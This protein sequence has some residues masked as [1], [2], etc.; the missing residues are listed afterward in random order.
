MKVKISTVVAL[1]AASCV[2]FAA[3]SLQPQQ[4]KE[5]TKEQ[6]IEMMKQQAATAP[7]HKVL[8]AM[9]GDFSMAGKASLMPG[10]DLEWK[11]TD[12]AR[13][14]LGGRFLEIDFA[15]EPG[16][17]F[18]V[19]GKTVLGFDTR[20]KKYTLWSIDTLGTYSVSAEGD[21]DAA[22]KELTLTGTNKEQGMDVKFKYVF[23]LSGEKSRMMDV[24]FAIP[25]APNGQ[26]WQK[27]IE[28]K[29]TKK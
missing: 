26:E 23:T 18:E 5:P 19:N 1:V 3:H 28:V 22:K 14:I 9:A 25:G 24:Y 7:E 2:G 10:L 8:E 4:G 15:S 21:F 12:K 13:M 20:T 29:C 6:V 11:G 16:E 27:Q 17:K